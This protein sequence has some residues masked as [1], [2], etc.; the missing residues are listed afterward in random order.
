MTDKK[1]T[2]SEIVKA[3]E[4]IKKLEEAYDNYYDSSKGMPYDID[5]TLLHSAI[6]FKNCL[7]EINRLQAE[8]EKLFADNQK[9]LSVMLWGNKK[10]VKNLLN[11]IKAEAIKEFAERL[12][13]E[14]EKVCIDREGD[15]VE[16]DN[17]I[18]DTVA[19]WCKETSNNLLKELVGEDNG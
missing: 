4:L 1:L 9:Y 16:A 7:N 19:N 18:Y 13:K 14:A 12:N 5:A 6:C 2:D 17:T 15:F 8:N 3:K 10:N 11:Q